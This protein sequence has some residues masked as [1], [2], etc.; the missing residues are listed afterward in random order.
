MVVSVWMLPRCSIYKTIP[1]F[2]VCLVCYLFSSSCKLT[3]FI[4]PYILESG[5]GNPPLLHPYII[6]TGTNTLQVI[7]THMDLLFI[8]PLSLHVTPESDQSP[9]SKQRDTGK[10]IVSYPVSHTYWTT[11]PYTVDVTLAELLAGSWGNPQSTNKTVSIQSTHD[12]RT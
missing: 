5:V 9:L 11:A 1:F 6:L 8:L 7:Q 4:S 10:P 2:K 3:L 12:D